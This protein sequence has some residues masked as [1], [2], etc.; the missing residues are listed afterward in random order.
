MIVVNSQRYNVAHEATK[1]IAQFVKYGQHREEGGI[2]WR[3]RK[4]MHGFESLFFG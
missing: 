4:E 1:S 3:K 2:F